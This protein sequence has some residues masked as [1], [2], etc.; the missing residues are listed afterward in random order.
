MSGWSTWRADINWVLSAWWVWCCVRSWIFV[1]HFDS[2]LCWYGFW[3]VWQWAW[4]VKIIA[5]LQ[6]WNR[7]KMNLKSMAILIWFSLSCFV[8]FFFYLSFAFSIIIILFLLLWYR[9]SKIS[10]SREF[11]LRFA[12]LDIC[13]RLP[14]G[15]DASILRYPFFVFFS[16]IMCSHFEHY[17]EDRIL[18]A[19]MF[20]RKKKIGNGHCFGF[21]HLSLI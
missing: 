21:R 4:K 8:F 12:G 15:F 20:L 11:L 6:Q 9:R 7:P 2:L 10:Y 3:G 5:H 18:L 16:Y 17:C 19:L 13:K 1:V 14:D